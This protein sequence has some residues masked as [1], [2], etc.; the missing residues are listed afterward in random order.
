M[1]ADSTAPPPSTTTRPETREGM[2][3]AS[4]AA[5]KAGQPCVSMYDLS[6]PCF[7]RNARSESTNVNPSANARRAPKRDLPMPFIPTMAIQRSPRWDTSNCARGFFRFFT[8]ESIPVASDGRHR[9]SVALSSVLGP[10]MHFRRH[11]NSF[12][13]PRRRCSQESPA[14]NTHPVV[15]ENAG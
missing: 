1:A 6:A 7:S 10:E 9:F 8:G 11:R 5:R 15:T 12:P 4:S 13:F 2:T 14:R 3:I